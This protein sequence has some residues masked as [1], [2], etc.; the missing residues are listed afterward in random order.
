M[1]EA[2]VVTP[3][4]SGLV[5]RQDNA[6]KLILAVVYSGFPSMH[7]QKTKTRVP[8]KSVY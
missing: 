3:E 1:A 8:E 5:V 6:T 2:Q 4:S 7:L